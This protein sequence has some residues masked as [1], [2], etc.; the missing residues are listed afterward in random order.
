MLAEK[1]FRLLLIIVRF[2]AQDSETSL[3][4][5]QAIQIELENHSQEGCVF[6]LLCTLHKC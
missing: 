6:P 3:T 4:F 2:K 1:Q 5:V